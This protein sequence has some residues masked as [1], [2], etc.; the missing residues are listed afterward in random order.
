MLDLRRLQILHEFAARGTIAATAAALGYTPSAVSQQLAA[1]ERET[2][3]QL[4]D[5]TARSAE[6]TDAGRLLL[7]H[8]EQILA[9][10]EAAES[11]LAAQTGAPRGRVTVTAFP[12]AAVAFA[13]SLARSLRVHEGMQLV[14]RQ[15]TEGSGTRQVRTAEADI[16]LVDDWS[17]RV[18]DSAAGTLRHYPL[19]RDPLVLA[20][21]EGHRLADPSVPVDLADLLDES[22]VT[23]PTGEPSRAA[24]DR[25]LGDVGGAP[26]AVWEFEGIGTILS[27]VGRGLGIAAVP[28]LSFAS[29]SP[30]LV[31]RRLPNA[32]VRKIYAVVRATSVRRPAIEVTLEALVEAARDVRRTLAAELGEALVD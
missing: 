7:G 26:G 3:T 1:L 23:A 17:G 31:H 32:P 6:L 16:S 15:T 28:A 13:P 8:A 21:P 2:G 29:A 30:G 14:L 10:V 18:P 5:R 27:L 4:L 20:V 11:V 9:M 19:L 22:W 12:T 25:L 24:I